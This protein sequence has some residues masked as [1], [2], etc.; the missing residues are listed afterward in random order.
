MIS[1]LY[2][3][4]E[5]ALLEI[6]KLFLETSNEFVVDTR[7]SAQ[8]GLDLLKDHSF[9]AIISD[10]QMPDMDGIAFLKVVRERFGDIPFILFTGRG[11]EE[12]VI[13]AIN[14]G[15]DFY[16]QKG[17][18]PTAQFAELSHKILQ[19]VRRRQVEISLKESERRYRDVVETQTEFISRFKPDGIHVFANEA[20]CRHFKKRPDEIIGH[21]FIPTIPEEDRDRVRRHFASFTPDH[22]VADIEHR[23]I[24]PDG[25]IRWHKWND[26]AIFDDAGM[27][28]EFQSIGKDITD[29]KQV[30]EELKQSENLYRTIF[31]TTGAASIISGPDTTILL[32]NDGWE[33]LTGVP[34]NEQ[35][36]KLS[37]TVFFDKDDAKRMTQ[38]HHARR[39]DPSLAPS[40]Y[41]SRVI[42]AKKVV[43][44]GY[45]NVH[46]IPG[47]KNSVASLV[48]IT[49]RKQAEEALQKSEE[50]YRAIVND[51]TE[52]IV[53]FTPDGTVTFTNE[54]YQVYFVPLLDL[55]TIEGKNIRELMQVKNYEEIENFLSKLTPET[56]IHEMEHMVNGWNGKI[57]WQSWSV[58]ALFD[59]D[60]KPAEYQV[61]GRDI[62]T[63]KR[64]EA[65]LQQVSTK[66]QQ[67]FKNMINA[68][69]VWESVFDEKGNYISFR[70]GQFNDAYARIAKLKYKDVRG[71]DVFEV[72]PATEQS[73]VEVYGS[74][75]TTG[76]PRVFDMYHEPTNGWYH[77]NAYRPTDS[78]S[79]V[80]VI[81]EDIT[82]RRQV[83]AELHA[84]YE[85]ITATEEEL[86]G[87]FEELSINEQRIRESEEQYRL[88]VENSYNAIFIYRDN[89]ILFA[90][91][92]ATDLSGFTHD[93]LMEKN[94]W[95]LVH[96]DDRARMQESRDRRISG[97][98]LSPNITGR[99]IRKSGEVLDSEF[100]IS[101][102]LYQNQPALLGIIKDISEQKRAEDALRKSE[103]QYRLLAENVHDVIWTADINMNLTYMSSSVTELRGYTPE[104]ALAESLSDALTKESYQKILEKRGQVM[105]ALRSGG[106]VPEKQIMDLEFRCKNGSTVWTEVVLTPVF[107]SNKKPVGVVGVT[108]DITLRRQVEEAQRQS[109]EKFRSIV[110]TSLDMI[111]EIDPRGN[112]RYA[113]P[114][115]QAILGYL[116]EELI[117][118]SITDLVPE[119]A[120]SFAIQELRHLFS[121]GRSILPLEVPARHRDGH[122]LVLEIRPSLTDTTGKWEG[123]RGVAVDITE[124]KKAEEALQKANRQLKLLGSITRHD[125]LN[126]IAVILG[127][128]KITQKKFNDP[129]LVDYLKKMESA[130]IAVREQIEFTRVYQDLGTHEPQWIDLDTVIPRA[131]VPATITLNADV[132]GVTLYA[133]PILEKVFFNLLDNSIRH[134]ERVTDIRVSSLQSGEDLVVVWEDNGV[135]IT[136]NEKE[137]IFERGFGKHTGLGMFLVREILALT[138]ITI[139]ETGVPGTGARFEITVPKGKYR[140]VDRN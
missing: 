14:N 84:A 89:Q 99:I 52:M 103:A 129:A 36:N 68:F 51:Q 38:Y 65:A 134:G 60:G 107:D 62:T 118:K 133:D 37:W 113:S 91:R 104:E 33:K 88:V 2:V 102:I 74:V 137:R 123:L 135:G 139:K 10:Y 48:D 63:L 20:Y 3:D 101:R 120:K 16:L 115:T 95:D 127:F 96:R 128:L 82:E 92:R 119:E 77:C 24:M 105:A 81:F 72:W 58:R 109:E 45:V 64:N 21:R 125:I 87:Q 75:A 50:R 114:Q 93:E 47:T 122:N 9:D 90:N 26:H 97:S 126:K 80:C 124:R 110:E 41:E 79:Q 136:A 32:A 85:Q 100:F 8:V 4:D 57:C 17:G 46:M 76:I 130:T 18:D 69:I 56:P 30:E 42:D 13:E 73:W 23:V 117:G 121:Q 70:F 116:P 12:V 83:E 40:V 86:R 71:K 43:H 106:P 138:G 140:T 5:P 49:E 22:P 31:N 131:H 29:R 111:W 112:F 19:A 27:V 98:A 7:P 55:D 67:I 108:R 44:N 94:I 25:S 61:V 78:R 11:R 15:A 28:I 39:K 66:L 34:R 35:E 59:K 6:A 1:V 54:A 53:R 132:Q